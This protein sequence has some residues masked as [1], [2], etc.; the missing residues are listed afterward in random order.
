MSMA[1]SLTCTQQRRKCIFLRRMS[2]TSVSRRFV[3]QSTSLK[4]HCT[5]FLTPSCQTV[6]FDWRESESIGLSSTSLVRACYNELNFRVH[7]EATSTCH[8]LTGVLLFYSLHSLPRAV[9]GS[10]FL[11]ILVNFF[12]TVIIRTNHLCKRRAY[13]TARPLDIAT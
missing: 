12:L 3:S 4:I 6:L 9:N 10:F 7:A 1:C 5:I 2:E 11:M 13:G 8:L